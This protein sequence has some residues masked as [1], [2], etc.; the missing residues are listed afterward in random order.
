MTTNQPTAA[1]IHTERLVTIW[2]CYCLWLA[3]N[4]QAIGGA[5]KAQCKESFLHATKAMKERD[6]LL[7]S[8]ASLLDA[9]KDAEFELRFMLTHHPERAGGGYSRVLIACQ[10]AIEAAERRRKQ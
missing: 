7:E 4:G 10:Q 9:C 3:D 2:D 8:E 1:D 6:A 5:K